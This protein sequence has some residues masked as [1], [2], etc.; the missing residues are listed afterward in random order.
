MMNNSRDWIYGPIES[1][2]RWRGENRLSVSG[3]GF[4]AKGFRGCGVQSFG[5]R[6]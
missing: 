4:G 2:G 5:F 1:V 3:L 6:V